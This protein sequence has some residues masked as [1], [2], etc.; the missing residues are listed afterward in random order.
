MAPALPHPQ[1]A[2]RGARSSSSARQHAGAAACGGIPRAYKLPWSACCLEPHLLGLNGRRQPTASRL[3]VA[4]AAAPV[5][6]VAVAANNV[7]PMVVSAPGPTR[8][9]LLAAPADEESGKYDAVREH[10]AALAAYYEGGSRHAELLEEALVAADDIKTLVTDAG[11]HFGQIAR[12]SRAAIL[13]LH[14]THACAALLVCHYSCMLP[15]VNTKYHGLRALQ[16]SVVQSGAVPPLVALAQQGHAIAFE[17]L[18]ILCYRNNV[19]CKQ[20]AA[21]GI[22]ALIICDM[23]RERGVRLR[24][25]GPAAWSSTRMREPCDRYARSGAHCPDAGR[26]RARRPGAAVRHV[27]PADGP[28]GLLRGH[29]RARHHGGPGAAAGGALP[30]AHRQRE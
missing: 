7:V 11:Q 4:Q 8:P 30:R 1:R 6:A 26:Q 14:C 27:L 21:H 10:L 20:I 3:P 18:Q 29:A 28:G 2:M 13:T 15:A 24:R 25:L 19:T 5:V 12:H 23:G 16:S 22:G 9:I 17:A